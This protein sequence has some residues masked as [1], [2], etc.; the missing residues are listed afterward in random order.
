M[1]KLC[2]VDVAVSRGLDHGAMSVVCQDAISKF[3]GASAN[4]IMSVSDAAILEA[5]ASAEAL[6]LVI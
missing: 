1:M 3:M 4:T 2:D 6:V 5:M